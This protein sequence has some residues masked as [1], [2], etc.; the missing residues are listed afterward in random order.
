M[1]VINELL[2]LLQILQLSRLI[3]DLVKNAISISMGNNF[4]HGNSNTSTLTESTCSGSEP[5]A[6]ERLHLLDF[7]PTSLSLHHSYDNGNEHLSDRYNSSLASFAINENE[8]L[9]DDF[10]LRY[11]GL[12][13]ESKKGFQKDIERSTNI[14]PR[15]LFGTDTSSTSNSNFNTSSSCKDKNEI[16]SLEMQFKELSLRHNEF[17][18]DKKRQK[19]KRNFSLQHWERQKVE[20]VDGSSRPSSENHK[21]YHSSSRRICCNTSD[22]DLSNE[23]DLN[24]ESLEKIIKSLQELLKRKEDAI[25]KLQLENSDAKDIISSKVSDNLKCKTEYE[26]IESKFLKSEEDRKL[27]V[28]TIHEILDACN[29]LNVAKQKSVRLID[30]YSGIEDIASLESELYVAIEN[31]VRLENALTEIKEKTEKI[32]RKS[33][34]TKLGNLGKPNT[35]KKKN[36]ESRPLLGKESFVKQVNS[37]KKSAKKD[38]GSLKKSY[39]EQP[40]SA[41]KEVKACR[42]SRIKELVQEKIQLNENLLQVEK[43]LF[44]KE[45]QLSKCKNEIDLLVQELSQMDRKINRQNTMLEFSKN[46][47]I[48]AK[49][50]IQSKK[51]ESQRFINILLPVC[52]DEDIDVI[53]IP[54][55]SYSDLIEFI[56]KR[57]EQYGTKSNNE[58]ATDDKF[59]NSSK[60]FEHLSKE[61]SDYKHKYEQLKKDYSISRNE[62][63]ENHDQA[64]LKRKINFLE[65]SNRAYLEEVE[66]MKLTNQDCKLNMQELKEK[67]HVMRQEMEL[68]KYQASLAEKSHEACRGKLERRIEKLKRKL[69]DEE[70]H[71]QE[72]K[73][74]IL[75]L[76]KKVNSGSFNDSGLEG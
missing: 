73:K 65:E 16:F 31:C 59:S 57:K 34:H 38:I 64:I 24:V 17:L 26:L 27:Q 46:R 70:N 61:L 32:L 7:A 44:E 36:I 30:N 75:F 60:E 3:L 62:K 8:S 42:A 15:A 49:T 2:K 43:E 10:V 76:Q 25:E 69:E 21:D 63:P 67:L 54:E 33:E 66:S 56:Q 1:S 50:E 45:K 41:I 9:E 47:S 6:K 14:S 53:E 39:Q 74:E 48:F 71:S 29:T 18:E 51:D 12:N 68:T 20:I 11:D 72:M 37:L 58:L 23:E 19:N 28:S 13:N 52:D 40:N 35:K 4:G 55:I 22:A 5:S